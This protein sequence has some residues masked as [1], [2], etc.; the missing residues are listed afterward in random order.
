M[1]E[2]EMWNAVCSSDKNYD[3]LFFYAVKTTGIFC[4]PSCKSKIPKKENIRY[5]ASAE[6]AGKAGFRPCKRCRSDLPAY[7]PMHEIALEVREKIQEAVTAGTHASLEE[8]GLTP[9]RLTEIFRQEYGM[10]PKEYADS[11][12]MKMAVQMLERTDQ[13]VI[14][15]AL[16]AGFSNISAFNRFF[17]KEIG[18]TPSQYRNSHKAERREG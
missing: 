12:R 17:K 14:D 10:T 7:E 6:E 1:T 5:F 4:R 3:E 13:K 16:A 18:K 9:K 15:I 11:L 2:E 8:V